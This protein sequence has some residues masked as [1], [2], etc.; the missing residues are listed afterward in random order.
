MAIMAIMAAHG[1]EG[2]KARGYRKVNWVVGRAMVLERN[3]R[4]RR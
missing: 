3:E 4:L 2:V 1:R